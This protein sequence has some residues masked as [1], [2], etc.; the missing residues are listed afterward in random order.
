VIRLV[1][2]QFMMGK[3][4]VRENSRTG[5]NHESK[6]KPPAKRLASLGKPI[7]FDGLSPGL[8]DKL[9]GANHDLQ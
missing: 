4:H 7:S 2:L 8:V 1:P 5:E 9:Y 6:P 3:E